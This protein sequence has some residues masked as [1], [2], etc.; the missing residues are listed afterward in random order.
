L[1]PGGSTHL[2]PDSTQTTQITTE[3]K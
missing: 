3:I 2:H 1:S